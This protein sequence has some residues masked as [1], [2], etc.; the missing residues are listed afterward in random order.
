MDGY[1]LPGSVKDKQSITADWQL[2]A[3]SLI[4]G[5]RFHEI[6]NVIKGNGILTEIF[7]TDWNLGDQPVDQVFQVSL[8][9]GGISAWHTHEVT[10]D[11]LFVS[12]GTARIVLYDAR[13]GSS[14]HGCINEFRAAAERPMIVLIPPKV[15]HGVQCI[16]AQPCLI[17]NLVDRAYRYEDPDHWRVPQDSPE[18]P[19]RFTQ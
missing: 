2:T 15:W 10:T 4:A 16:S 9:P 14:T 1:L 11:R 17:L 13:E 6:R 7:R 18:I 12:A 8:L 3:R 5:V 19:Y